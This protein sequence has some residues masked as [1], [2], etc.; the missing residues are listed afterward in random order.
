MAKYSY[1]KNFQLNKNKIKNLEI[2]LSNKKS[3][4]LYT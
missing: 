3:L 4:K 2:S 1:T